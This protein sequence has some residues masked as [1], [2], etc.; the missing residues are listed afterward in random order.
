[1]FNMHSKK[2]RIV[3]GLLALLLVLAMIVPTILQFIL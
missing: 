2:G 3:V 1:M